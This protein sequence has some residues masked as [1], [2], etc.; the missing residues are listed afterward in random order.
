M[1]VR[2]KAEHERSSLWL[3]SRTEPYGV[4]PQG[5]LNQ[6][7][8]QLY[9]ALG[10][11]GAA[12]MRCCAESTDFCKEA[13]QHLQKMADPSAP[14]IDCDAYPFVPEGW[15]VYRHKKACKLLWEPHKVILY[16][17]EQQKSKEIKGTQWFNSLEPL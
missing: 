6:A 13:A 8:T 16:F 17:S 14:W 10:N 5:V 1:G 15:K 2:P 3:K 11:D 7:E 9:K 12:I 4:Y